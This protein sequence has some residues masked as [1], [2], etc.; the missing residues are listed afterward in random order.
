MCKVIQQKEL[1]LP[2]PQ[3]QKDE[4]LIQKL[5]GHSLYQ[6]I[7]LSFCENI[8]EDQ[9]LSEIYEDHD[10]D[11][12]ADLKQNLLDTSFL[13][14]ESKQPI[15]AGEG[16]RNR[17]ILQNYALFEKGFNVHHFDQL[18]KHFVSA[19]HESWIQDDALFDLCQQRFD[20]LRSIFEDEGRDIENMMYLQRR[21]VEVCILHANN[22]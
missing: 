19:L 17:I 4:N 15:F 1:V 5:G 7:I 8:L 22:A 14:V 6:F 3:L 9:G 11:S 12:L 10:I 18:R 16:S 2:T 21:V 13:R 20:D